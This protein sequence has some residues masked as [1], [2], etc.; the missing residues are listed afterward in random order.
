M[1][2]F[3]LEYAKLLLPWRW[4]RV[5]SHGVLGWVLFPFRYL[6]RW[7]LYAPEARRLGNHCFVWFRKPT[8]AT[9]SGTI[10]TSA[11]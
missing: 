7:L 9:G 11:N 2:V 4:W 3:T 1:L 8:H 6:D 5:V 10:K